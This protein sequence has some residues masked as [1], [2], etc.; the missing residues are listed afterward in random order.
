MGSGFNMFRSPMMIRIIYWDRYIQD[1]RQEIVLV[2]IGF[3]HTW[4]TDPIM[5]WDNFWGQR[6]GWDKDPDRTWLAVYD[7]MGPFDAAGICVCIYIYM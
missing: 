6:L 1:L 7:K 4:E 3:N 2:S 5:S